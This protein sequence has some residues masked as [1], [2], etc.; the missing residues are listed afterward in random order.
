M[1]TFP[2]VSVLLPVHNGMPFLQESVESIRSQ[3]LAQ[4]ELIVLDDGSTDDSPRYLASVAD[5]RLRVERLEKGGLVTAL[6]HGLRT[7][8][9]SFVARIDADDVAY[10]DRL[11]LQY[12][13]LERNPDCVALGTQ[14]RRIDASSNPAFEGRYAR[15]PVSTSAIRWEALFRSPILHPSSM[16]RREAVLELGGYRSEFDVS[17]DYDLWTRLTARGR[18]ANLAETLLHY[19]MHEKAVSRIHKERQ[20]RQASRIAGAYAASLGAGLESKDIEDLYLFLT[21]A[22]VPAS[23]PIELAIAAFVTAL[24]FFLDSASR[25]D[26]DLTHWISIRQDDLR[27]R[28]T[29][30][31]RGSWSKPW[32]TLAWLRRAAQVDPAKAS[33]SGMLRRRLSALFQQPDEA[34]QKSTSVSPLANTGELKA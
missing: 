25:N 27:W 28:C 26:P 12:E 1:N 15:F 3:T 6:N 13:Y 24:G 21:R 16:F 29:K 14:C 8:R 20:I 7:A 17:E 10:P 4:F 22:E 5:P 2:L 33:M 19:R 32:Q 18:L 9:A 30:Q 31:A 23:R 34:S 11:R